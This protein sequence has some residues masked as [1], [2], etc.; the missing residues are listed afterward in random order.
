MIISEQW[1]RTFVDPEMNT[2]DLAHRLTMLGLEVDGIEPAAP[3]FTGVV[4]GEIVEIAAH[5]DADKLRICQVA[6]NGEGLTQVVCGAK[7]AA[8]GIK[9]PFATVGAKLPGDFKIKKAK[10]RGVESLG[11][12]CAAAELGLE[13]SS[14]GLLELPLDAPVGEDIRDYLSL[15]D[16][17]IEVDL[18]PN[19]GD[20]LSMSGV[21]REVAT[22]SQSALN[23][24]DVPVVVAS[25]E[26]K[27]S[28]ELKAV[29]E[30]PR[31]AGR[32]IRSVNVK[33][34]TP[35]WMSERLRRAGVRPL[36][37]VV[38]VT[39]Y[40]MLELG[41]PMHAFDLAKLDGGVVVRMAEQGEKLQLLDDSEVE[42]NADTLVIADHQ[43]AH[44]M[45]GIMGGLQSS[46]TDAT[47]DILLEAAFFNPDLIKGK[48]R[49]YGMHTDSSHRFERGVDPAL[50]ERAIERAT[51][52]LLDIVGGEAGPLVLA[53]GD[54]FSAKKESIVLRAS[55]IKRLLGIEF[56]AHDVVDIMQRLGMGV[57]VLEDGWRI[58]PPSF[59]F[60]INIEADLIEELMRLYGYD[61]IPYTLTSTAPGIQA[62]DE[63]LVPLDSLKLALV[64]RGYQEAVCYS[65]VSADLQ[66]TFEPEQPAV[67]LA[68]PISSELGVMRTSLI[69]GLVSTLQYNLNRQQKRLQIFETGLR[70]VP[71]S[72]NETNLDS[73]KQNPML[74]GLICGTVE[75]EGWNTD[76]RGYDFFDIKADVEALLAP[77]GIQ[78]FRFAVAQHPALHPGQSAEVLRILEDGSEQS[79]GVLG[80]LHPQLAKKLK[81]KQ[82]AFVFELLSDLISLGAVTQFQSLS[83]F[84]ASRRDLALVVKTSVSAQSLVDCIK[85]SGPEFLQEVSVFDLYEGE[86]LESG[87]KSV[88]LSLILQDFSRTLNDEE[89]ESSLS[90]ILSTLEKQLGATLRE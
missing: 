42:L 4:V 80:A 41:Q 67:A 27:L 87:S 37:P 17:L 8:Q 79:V 75:P 62:D 65:F 12:L 46:V 26:D 83:E 86:N 45:A 49:N 19:R 40:V 63:A 43:Q 82:K 58:T 39:N 11:M 54:N 32:I 31:Y 50:Q 55:R 52:L 81:L 76:T 66:K 53:E 33:A 5:P 70:F 69:P 90:T 23:Q 78:N 68:N 47:Q 24:V 57:A 13:E 30:C 16:Q 10:L 35:M 15:D 74:A 85:K 72:E 51:A 64:E 1:L 38:D 61:N 21:A 9:I 48:A 56:E 73:L 36:S 84:P 18:T 22:A 89:V 2:Q 29:V 7:N 20:C 28:V 25:I 3:E 59:R 34:E 44:A 71:A 88:A 77:A 60:D 14:E 6:G